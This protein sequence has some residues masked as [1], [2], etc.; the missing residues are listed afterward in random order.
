MGV[1]IAHV[2]DPLAKVTEN[3]CENRMYA[4]NLG[5]KYQL[6]HL[7]ALCSGTSLSLGSFLK[8]LG[9]ENAKN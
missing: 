4:I 9:N 2:R 1:S 3:N 6:R 5:S 7:Q 8:I